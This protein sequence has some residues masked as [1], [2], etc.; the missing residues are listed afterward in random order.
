MYVGIDHSTTG[1][2]VACREDGRVRSVF[3]IDR[4]EIEECQSVLEIID[5]RIGRSNITLAT[6][7]Y[8]YG[9]GI[10]EITDIEAVSDRGVKDLLGLGYETG[11]GAVVFDQ[12]QAS[13]IPAVV[14]PGVHDGLGTLHPLFEHH[15]TWSGGDKVAAIRSAQERFRETTEDGD[16]FIWACASSSCMSG[17]VSDGRLKGF[18]HWLGLVHGW[19]DLEAVRRGMDEGFDDILMQCGILPR[20][21]HDLSDAHDVTDPDILEQ[22]YW[23]TLFNIYSLYPFAQ[24]ICGDSLDG[25]VLSG[26][27]VRREQPIDIGRRV[28]EHCTDTAPVHILEPYASARGAALVAEDVDHGAEH[29]LGIEVGDVPCQ[30]SNQPCVRETL[31]TSGQTQ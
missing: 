19:P 24:G 1:I 17:L 29:V 18:F 25:I 11:A 28:Y 14:L 10:A 15:S 2:K 13:S 26:R 31:D 22:V 12:L 20:L 7:T 30:P 6:V 27:L 21:G 9:N 5:D 4:R 16:T 23:S 8:S 3:R